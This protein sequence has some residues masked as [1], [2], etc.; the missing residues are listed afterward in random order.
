L[1]F[2][3]RR[4]GAVIRGQGRS[5][6]RGTVNLG[7]KRATASGTKT[8]RS[9]CILAGETSPKMHE[10]IYLIGLVVVV[11]FMLSLLGLR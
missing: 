3:T 5:W 1:L 9:R 8:V 7:R 6:L 2:Y 11:M 4:I 10:I